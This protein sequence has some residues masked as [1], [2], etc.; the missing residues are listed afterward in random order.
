MATEV[1]IKILAFPYYE[2]YTDPVTGKTAKRELLASRGDTVELSDVDLERAKRFDAIQTDADREVAES[3]D[4]F[5]VETASV[6]ELGNWITNEKPTVDTVVDAA[7]DDPE[8]AQRLLDAENLSTGQEPR[9]GVEEGLGK[10]IA[11]SGDGSG[12]G[13]VTVE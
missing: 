5:S 4:A 12:G 11:G 6:E 3:S 9:V 13:E 10:V 2:D 8:L 7:G 1:T